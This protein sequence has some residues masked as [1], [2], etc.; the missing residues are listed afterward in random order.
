MTTPVRILV[1]LATAGALLAAA[2]APAPAGAVVPP[3]NCG[4]ITVKDKKW[5][6]KADQIRC[7]KAKKY[8]RAYIRSYSTPRYYKCKPGPRRSSLW[9]TCT[10]A[11]YNP[12]RQFIIIKR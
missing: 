10:A 4:T 12:D 5:Q 7:R 2:L 3:R 11:R 1:A 8:S 9:R 6:I